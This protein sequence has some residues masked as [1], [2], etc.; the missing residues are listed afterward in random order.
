MLLAKTIELCPYDQINNKSVQWI[1]ILIDILKNQFSQKKNWITSSIEELKQALKAIQSFIKRISTFQSIKSTVQQGSSFPSLPNLLLTYLSS[2]INSKEIKQS[3]KIIE[4]ES[5]KT[6][7]TLLQYIPMLLKSSYAR[8]QNTLVIYLGDFSKTIRMLAIEI[9]SLLPQCSKN[10]TDASKSVFDLTNRILEGT[11]HIINY[12]YNKI[13]LLIDNNWSHYYQLFQ[14]SESNENNNNNNNNNLHFN[15]SFLSDYSSAESSSAI[16]DRFQF[17]YL[18]YKS[19][20]K[21]LSNLYEFTYNGIIVEYPIQ[22]TLDIIKRSILLAP[23]W[24]FHQKSSQTLDQSHVLRLLTFLPKIQVETMNLLHSIILKTQSHLLPFSNQISNMLN[25][26]LGYYNNIHQSPFYGKLRSS[27][28]KVISI[29][30]HFFGI[31]CLDSL[32]IPF[33]QN[34]IQQFDDLYT[35][36]HQKTQIAALSV[37]KNKKKRKRNASNSSNHF[38]HLNVLEDQIPL[39]YCTDNLFFYQVISI[40]EIILLKCGSLLSIEIR[41]QIDQFIL[42]Y[43]LPYSNEN[44]ISVYSPLQDSK[45]ILALFKVLLASIMKPLLH[46]PS[47]LSY[48]VRLFSLGQFDSNI[49]VRLFCLQASSYCDIL[50][51]PIRTPSVP[52][53]ADISPVALYEYNLKSKQKN[54]NMKTNASTSVFSNNGSSNNNNIIEKTT[55]EIHIKQASVQ[56]EISKNVHETQPQKDQSN[57]HMMIDDSSIIS[58]TSE[59]ENLEKPQETIAVPS[60]TQNPFQN[61]FNVQTTEN[62]EQK[63]ED[64]SSESL[65]N[66]KPG[67]FGI[68]NMDKSQ[69]FL[70]DDEESLDFNACSPDPS[71]CSSDE[72][73]E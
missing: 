40:F 19:F 12:F 48:G 64:L 18:L 1:S 16:Y 69:I 25:Q 31:S 14:S 44:V 6:L 52:L 54:N 37:N 53:I 7:S 49:E 65:F 5:L 22:N 26:I 10:V 27:I 70:S 68:P 33:I 61:I 43:L 3:D 50:L 34:T 23:D 73:I 38:N 11:H 51:H 36:S 71:E 20:L 63:K 60:T 32:I 62:D 17:I 72:D 15:F 59:E 39:S 45:C 2:N 42:N 8:I 13:D 30:V 9:I 47:V 56:Q 41:T 55:N 57:D 46:L 58:Q 28:Y 24:L 67:N 35:I 66:Q 4:K 29:S 21:I